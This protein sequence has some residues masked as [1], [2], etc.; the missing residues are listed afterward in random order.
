MRSHQLALCV[1]LALTIASGVKSAP[2]PVSYFEVASV[3]KQAYIES[4]RMELLKFALFMVSFVVVAEAATNFQLL[5]L[6]TGFGQHED[7]AL[8]EESAVR[9]FAAFAVCV[10]V[11]VLGVLF[12]TARLQLLVRALVCTIATI[13]LVEFFKGVLTPP[14][15]VRTLMKFKDDNEAPSGSFEDQFN[16]KLPWVQTAVAAADNNARIVAITAVS[17]CAYVSVEAPELFGSTGPSHLI[18]AGTLLGVLAS[19]AALVTYSSARGE[20][21]R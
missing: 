7:A 21:F 16:K 1:A 19:F 15:S 4:S 20:A 13:A 8:A 9:S 12:L 14:E 2:S 5:A 18:Q 3:A 11:C 10:L 6:V 17:I